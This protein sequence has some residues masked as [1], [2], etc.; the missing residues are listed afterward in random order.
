MR[1]YDGPIFSVERRDGRD[2]VVH[3]PVVAVIAVDRQ[4]EL[5]LVRQHRVPVGKT[6]L[7]LPA[8]FIDPDE[9][10]LEAARREL[11]EE[12]GLRDGQWVEVAR[13]YTSAGFTDEK[14]HLFLA[15]ALEQGE[16]TPEEVEE[17]EIVR[18]PLSDVAVLVEECEDAKTVIGLL[19]LTRIRGL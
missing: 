13:F 14:V 5:T 11:A 6:L 12:T 3:A 9:S 8:G 19:L 15:T 1:L 17:L 10:P 16:A 18:V 2:V 4:N 7:E